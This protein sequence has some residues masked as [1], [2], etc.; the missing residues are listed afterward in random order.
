MTWYKLKHS[1]ES[2]FCQRDA[3]V[4]R[5]RPQSHVSPG[6]WQEHKLEPKYLAVVTQYWVCSTPVSLSFTISWGLLRLMSIKSVILSNFLIL[7]CPLLLLP[8]I[9]SSIKVFCKSQFFT[10]GG[11]SNGASASISILSMNIQGWFPLGL[12]CLTPCCPK[13]SQE[14]S[15]APQFKNINSL[16]LSLF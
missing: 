16:M 2:M 15:P 8:L 3:L 5:R 9:F 7:C 14:S 6:V 13:D 1:S 4:T 12:T 10:S 11:Q